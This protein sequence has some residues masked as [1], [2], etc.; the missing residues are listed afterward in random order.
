MVEY[1]PIVKALAQAN[2]NETTKAKLKR[3]FDVAYM[4]VN[5]QSFFHEDEEYL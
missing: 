4:I 3:K 5:A 2:I 1:S